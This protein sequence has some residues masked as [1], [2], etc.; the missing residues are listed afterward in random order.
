MR[1]LWI[2]V[3]ALCLVVVGDS[4]A[5]RGRWS[6][7]PSPQ[8][9]VRGGYDYDIDA[10]SAGGQARWPFGRRGKYQLVPSGDVFFADGVADWQGNV[11]WLLS[12]GPRGGFYFGIGVGYSSRP[13]DGERVFNRLVGLRLSQ[14][15]YV[16][17]RWTNVDGR[18]L[19][20]LVVGY[21]ISL[22]KR[23]DSAADIFDAQAPEW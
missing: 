20:R 19:F 8:I 21:N 14:R 1:V 17:S 5:Q 6:S 9:G 18:N 22:G 7:K 11:D 3:L 12:P 23:R 13:I 16:E 10:W 4:A 2:W 15:L